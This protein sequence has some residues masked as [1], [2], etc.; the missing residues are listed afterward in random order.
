MRDDIFPYLCTD[1]HQENSISL[2]PVYNAETR[3]IGKIGR[4]DR[5]SSLDT[6]DSFAIG[7]SDADILPWREPR[8]PHDEELRIKHTSVEI[9][10]VN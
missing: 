5:I 4:D 9:K 3:P 8:P 1:Y 7:G 6:V 2:V 10:T